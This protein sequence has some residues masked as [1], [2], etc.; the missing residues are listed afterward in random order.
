MFGRVWIGL[1]KFSYDWI[2]LDRLGIG[3]DQ[4]G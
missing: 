1:G 4:Y 3:L 2:G